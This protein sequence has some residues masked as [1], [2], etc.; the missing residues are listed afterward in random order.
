MPRSKRAFNPRLFTVIL[1]ISSIIA[2]VLAAVIPSFKPFLVRVIDNLF[3]GAAI[4]L[5][6][7]L[8][9]RL[10]KNSERKIHKELIDKR[11]QMSKLKKEERELLKHYD[12]FALFTRHFGWVAL[13]LF[14]LSAVGT[15]LLSFSSP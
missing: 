15:I 8:Y 5:M 14:A 6:S 2:F 1:G 3:I 13:T 11:E 4:N 12:S 7:M 9:F 10:R